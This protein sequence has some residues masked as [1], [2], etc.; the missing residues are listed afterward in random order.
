M[1]YYLRYSPIKNLQVYKLFVLIL[2]LCLLNL[3]TVHNTANISISSPIKD[4][5][6]L[7]ELGHRFFFDKNLS[8]EKNISCSTCHEPTLA[9]T[10]GYKLSVNSKAESL[11]R[12]SPS[13]LN[14]AQRESFNW[15][16]S[17]IKTLNHQMQRP[18]Y[19]QSP[20]ELGIKGNEEFILA[21]FR[22]S[23]EY[24][25][26][27]KLA[28]TKK[29][30]EINFQD[31][32][33]AIESYIVQLIS[34]NS[35]YDQFLNGRDSSLLSYEEWRG[36]RIFHSDSIECSACHGGKD[37]FEPER[38]GQ[39]ANI[40]LYNCNDSYP[41]RDRGLQDE[42]SDPD[43]N[44]VFRIPTLRNIAITSP[45]Y[46]DG[47]EESLESVILNYERPG[48][49]VEYGDCKGDGSLHPNLDGRLQK[50]N[51]SETDRKALIA[52]LHCLTDTSY[53]KDKKFRNPF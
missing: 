16:N 23:K 39:F 22:S 46:H 17:S 49:K 6:A 15:A 48:R 36:F 45:Y 35:R 8:F 24:A 10:D 41:N 50:F 27:F 4:S 20:V 19:S 40:G 52:F 44:G 25:Q 26:L 14:I 31:V 43:Y 47:S 7:I 28:F 38:G 32:E 12:N 42:T 11:L 53:L 34:R 29:I 13:L 51:L 37:F 9:F 2:L 18:L 21:R 33:Q 30:K 1:V 3:C 5:L